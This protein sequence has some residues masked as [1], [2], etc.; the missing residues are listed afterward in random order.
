[1]QFEKVSIPHFT[2]M[3]YEISIKWKYEARLILTWLT[4]NL[5]HTIFYHNQK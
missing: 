5:D 3:Y 4:Q 2:R 1:M